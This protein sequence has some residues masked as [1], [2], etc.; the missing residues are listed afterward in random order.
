MRPEDF[1]PGNPAASV[2][3]APA[4]APRFNEAGGFLPRK[5][6]PR[7]D[8]VQ[9]LS[10]ASMRPEDFSPGNAHLEDE[11]IDRAAAASMRPEDFS[12]G[13]TAAPTPPRRWQ[14]R[15]Q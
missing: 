9:G 7:P 14:R 12:P 2:P 8:V 11:R 10:I 6:R 5:H 3:R 13:N 15:L 4:P 1:S